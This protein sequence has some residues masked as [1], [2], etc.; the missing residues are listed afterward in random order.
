MSLV[1]SIVIAMFFFFGGCLQLGAYIGKTPVEDIPTYVDGL[2]LNSWSLAVAAVLFMLI[3]LRL[4]GEQARETEYEAS[5]IVER[6]VPQQAVQPAGGVSYFRTEAVGAQVSEHQAAQP[7]RTVQGPQPSSREHTS[8]AT[9]PPFEQG[10]EKARTD[11]PVGEAP[12]PAQKKE[13]EN[14]DLNFFKL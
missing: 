12:P 11:K 4:H 14:S 13:E 1:V 10:K 3:E 6:P 5:S 2:M 8:F 9:P 7:A